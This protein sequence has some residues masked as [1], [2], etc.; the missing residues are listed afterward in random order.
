VS[1]PETLRVSSWSFPT[2]GHL[3]EIGRGEPIVNR[4]RSSGLYGWGGAGVDSRPVGG[5]ARMAA[6]LRCAGADPPRRH[7]TDWH[8]RGGRPV[9]RHAGCRGC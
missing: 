3:P 6:S 4:P 1:R 2:A 5:L 9:A 7:R 8:P